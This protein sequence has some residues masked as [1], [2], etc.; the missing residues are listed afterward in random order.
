MVDQCAVKPT[1]VRRPL[2]NQMRRP[3]PQLKLQVEWSGVF[4][5][6]A[7]AYVYKNYW[8]VQEQLTSHED[9]LAECALIFTRCLRKYEYTVDNAAWFMSLFQRTVA[10]EF[11][12]HARR[13]SN[14]RATIVY[15]RD[16]DDVL[17]RE[18]AHSPDSNLG[19]LAAL[20]GSASCE[21]RT[22]LGLIARA[23][24]EMLDILLEASD[25]SALNRKWLRLAGIKECEID[26]VA[27]L[28]NL[29]T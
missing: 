16:D 3:L 29:L 21:L 23:P 28:R 7:R 25:L 4:E 14:K 1:I 10:N 13:A 24:S 27:E 5:G 11:T 9:A 15:A 2:R 22:V 12:D 6:W 26:V 18:N 19:Y 8:K 20:S 17:S